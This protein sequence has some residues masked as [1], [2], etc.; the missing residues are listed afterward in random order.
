MKGW[1]GG[2]GVVIGFV[3]KGIV[4]IGGRVLIYYI[5]FERKLGSRVLEDGSLREG[6]SG[7]V[8]FCFC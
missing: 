1:G 8:W 5:L 7:I 4:V 2:G 6:R 3:Y